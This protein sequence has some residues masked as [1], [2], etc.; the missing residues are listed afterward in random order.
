MCP[1]SFA[2]EHEPEFGVAVRE[3]VN[4]PIREEPEQTHE[5]RHPEASEWFDEPEEDDREG[6]SHGHVA[7]Q[8]LNQ[9]S[10]FDAKVIS[11]RSPPPTERPP[12]PPPTRTSLP[13]PPRRESV[14][15]PPRS[16]PP[17][18]PPAPAENDE[19]SD[20]GESQEDYSNAV[21]EQEPVEEPIH[22]VSP[23]ARQAPPPPPAPIVEPE[24]PVQLVVPPRRQSSDV[25]PARRSLP[26]PPPPPQDPQ[27]VSP[28][29][30][31]PTL[32]PTS[33]VHPARRS[34]PPPPPPAPTD[35]HETHD[36]DSEHD[37][38]SPPYSSE[39]FEDTYS[40]E[41]Q[42]LQIPSGFNSQIHSPV[43]PTRVPPAI[44]IPDQ[45]EDELLDEGDV[46]E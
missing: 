14:P 18:P 7:P 10:G 33:S 40:E 12:P 15:P 21:E 2:D 24:A 30:E 38:I 43:S 3:S 46:G 32:Q 36:R 20:Y 13:P 28:E 27:P 22:A 4:A 1:A 6:S 42:T 17:P 9:A 25:H 45:G 19:E 35:E 39:G 8:T 37:P 5:S 44:V 11:P 26:P 31:H 23:P 41:A 34:V 16:A 29:D